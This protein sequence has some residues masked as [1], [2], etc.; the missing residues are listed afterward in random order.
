[1]GGFA[2]RAM[3]GI[4]TFA[5]GGVATRPMLRWAGGGLNLVGEGQYNEAYV[6]L[7]DGRTIPVTMRLPQQMLSTQPSVSVPI[8]V[9]IV[10][11]K[12]DAD[13]SVSQRTGSNGVQE[14]QILVVQAVND[15]I[16]KGQFDRVLGQRYGSQPKA[17]RR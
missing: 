2:L 1:M 12:S 10:N 17:L 13:V 15:G 3:G 8:N 14:L 16:N 4:S 7:P 11:Q 5:M 6:P 9:S